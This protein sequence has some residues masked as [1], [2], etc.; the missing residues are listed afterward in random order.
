MVE[1]YYKPPFWNKNPNDDPEFV[2]LVNSE[3]APSDGKAL[4]KYLAKITK[5]WIEKMV[6]KHL[7][8]EH[9]EWR[10][11]VRF[12]KVIDRYEVSNFGRIF[13]CLCGV[14]K[15]HN[16]RLYPRHAI[17]KI[18]YNLDIPKDLF[19]YKYS[20]GSKKDTVSLKI[21]SHTAVAATFIPF[22]LNPPV[23]IES[24]AV[25]PDECK[26]YMSQASV[27]DHWDGN[28]FNN[29]VTNLRWTTNIG[30]NDRRKQQFIAAGKLKHDKIINILRGERKNRP[31]LSYIQS[32][33]TVTKFLC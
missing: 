27:I 28:P 29:H 16:I 20:K 9:E 31:R 12:G 15:R 14:V 6:D 32:E 30:N 3:I 11:L 18:E 4:D 21:H 10:P 5:D 24:W 25:T 1:N 8:I 23:S 7:S 13:D 17:V 19:E 2:E 33:S 22:D 26:E